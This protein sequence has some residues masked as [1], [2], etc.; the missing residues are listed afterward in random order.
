MPLELRQLPTRFKIMV[1][2]GPVIRCDDRANVVSALVHERLRGVYCA[3][4][5]PAFRIVNSLLVGIVHVLLPPVVQSSVGSQKVCFTFS[6]AIWIASMTRSPLT[7]KPNQP[8]RR[9]L[10]KRVF[11]A[12]GSLSGGSIDQVLLP[13]MCANTLRLAFLWHK[14]LIIV[15]NDI[16]VP[17]AHVKCLPRTRSFARSNTNAA[18]RN[19]D[20]L[21]IRPHVCEF[22]AV[23]CGYFRSAATSAACRRHTKDTKVCCATVAR[24]VC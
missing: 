17:L 16:W 14:P 18:R 6:P 23:G 19:C 5:P 13:C 22:S 2:G 4:R 1:D 24:Y 11:S 20:C 15:N 12:S 3:N 8:S 10:A 9:F 21:L 7:F